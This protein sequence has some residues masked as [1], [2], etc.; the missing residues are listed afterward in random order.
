MG[1]VAMEEMEE[2]GQDGRPDGGRA[3]LDNGISFDAA[4]QAQEKGKRNNVGCH[5]IYHVHL[6]CSHADPASGNSWRRLRGERD[7]PAAGPLCMA[8]LVCRGGCRMRGFPARGSV[9]RSQD[10]TRTSPQRD[11]WRCNPNPEIRPRTGQSSRGV[12]LVFR[13]ASA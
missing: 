4:E 6:A 13:E 1:V 10:H 2:G 12:N 8:N 11:G 7:R 3:G 9:A 5:L